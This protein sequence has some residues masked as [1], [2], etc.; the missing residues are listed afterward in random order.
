M[1]D[2][3]GELRCRAGVVWELG[4]KIPVERHLCG[5]TKTRNHGGS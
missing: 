3:E 1:G 4:Q 5:E 2:G